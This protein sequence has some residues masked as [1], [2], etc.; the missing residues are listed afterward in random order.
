MEEKCDGVV[1]FWVLIP[2]YGGSFVIP[3]REVQSLSCKVFTLRFLDSKGV[4][5]KCST[6]REAQLSNI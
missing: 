2:N 3:V 4:T 5:R 6:D 1:V